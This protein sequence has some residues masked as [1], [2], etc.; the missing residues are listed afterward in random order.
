[1][2]FAL[3]ARSAVVVVLLV[4]AVGPAQVTLGQVDNFEDGS[5]QNW[6]QGISS[7]GTLTSATGGPPGS[8]H[9]MQVT[10][11]GGFG[12]SSSRLTVFNQSQW[13]GNY[14]AAGVNA[15]EMDL[16]AP[17]SNAQTLSMRIAY[18]SGTGAGAPGY[19]STAAFSLPADGQWH[20]AVFLLS[21]ST[22][23]PIGAVTS[24]FDAFITAPQE[25]RILHSASPSLN[26][27]VIAAVVG[28]DNVR[29]SFVPVPEPAGGLAAV[30]LAAGLVGLARRRRAARLTSSPSS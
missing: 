7:L 25:M 16:L 28:V 12:G 10:A 24:P 27:D 19:S 17:T 14:I 6:A 30:A 29:A 18:K 2:R 15:V 23:T 21:N 20:H 4:P 8:T 5:L 3:F 13:R 22:M 1:M 9:Y 11:L 26:G